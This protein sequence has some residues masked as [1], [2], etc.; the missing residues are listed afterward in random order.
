MKKKLS[1]YQHFFSMVLMPVVAFSANG[2]QQFIQVASKANSY[3]NATCTLLDITALNKNPAAIVFASPLI[4]NE[5][6]LNPHPIGVH[7]INEKW[8]IINLDQTAMSIGSRF[9]V[10]Y[11]S[12]PDPAFQFVHTVSKENLKDNN[13]RSFID[14]PGLNNKPDAKI[15]FIVNGIKGGYNLKEINIQYDNEA[16]QSGKDFHCMSHRATGTNAKPY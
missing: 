15:Q 14:H 16:G 6:N 5:V 9:N 7:F 12:T 1:I 8:S 2:Q 10:Q 11:F 13:T 4:E 3:C